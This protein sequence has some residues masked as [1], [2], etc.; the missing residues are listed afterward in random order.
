MTS[1]GLPSFVAGIAAL[2]QRLLA[3]P[4]S[5]TVSE[6]A[7]RFRVVPSYSAE[8]GP[9]VTARTPYLR[10]IMDSFSDPTVNRVVF[11]KCA[12]IGATEAGLNIIGYFIHQDPSTIMVVQPT[13]DD[14]KDFS[15]EQL[16]TTIAETPAL[17]ALVSNAV[18][19]SKNTLTGKLFPG[20]S[21]V[22]GG[23]NSPRFFRRRTV[24]V[25]VLEEV[26]GY[27]GSSTAKGEGDQMR[28]AEK[29]AE[30]MGYRR[31]IYIN[32]TPTTKGECRISAEFARSD[33]RY[34]VVPCP[35]C[36]QRQRLVWDRLQY[37]GRESPAYQCEHC[38]GLIEEADKDAMV[39][40]GEWVVTSPLAETRGYHLN[41]LYS[42]FVR[43]S[44][45][46]REWQDAQG[47]PD[48]LQ[49]FVNTALGEEWE[50]R[51]TQDLL[52]VVQAR[53][54]QYEPE[55]APW[56]VP[57]GACVLVCGVDKQDAELHYV[58]RA[59]G[60]G[61]QSWLIDWG[62][63]RG[64]TSRPEVWATL[65]EWRQTR[66]WR[67]EGG[68]R[69]KIRAM[70]IDSGDDP[71]PV[72]TYT[73]A[74]LAE[75]VFAVKGA[76]DPNAD[77]LPKKFTKTR[78]KSRLY[79]LGTQAIKKRLFRRA[80]LNA[81]VPYTLDAGPTFMHFNERADAVYFAEFFSQKLVRHEYRGRSVSMYVKRTG[82]RDEK[83]DCEVYAY[84]ALHLGPV[85]IPS[86]QSEWERVMA[87]G[88]AADSAPGSTASSP[89]AATPPRPSS[90]SSW[91]PRRSGGWMRW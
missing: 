18:K 68:A 70:C 33:Q 2:R 82:E 56:R 31:K 48:A 79:L 57:R 19:D 14:A 24:R 60:P 25:V 59:Y 83:L 17:S 74:R 10:E 89:P 72:Y 90:P 50:D 71:D 49:V 43:W 78:A 67:H 69:L 76:A 7:D 20:G 85:S 26:N 77:I 34:Y 52:D 47:N 58:V 38:D 9:W 5:L 37:T 35:H 51:A 32:S 61:E 80:G 27:G 4:P 15:K 21:I 84:A 44:T 54:Q 1:A 36:D 66:T 64:D 45:L 3:P 13:V 75:Y 53:A 86:L 12:R 40:S 91:L 22:L 62:I 87:E 42:P 55:G 28:L 41:A 63:F 39:A 46:V 29:R 30:T 65:D 73:K 8:A 88:A 16:A 6:W 11:K 81:P 23:A